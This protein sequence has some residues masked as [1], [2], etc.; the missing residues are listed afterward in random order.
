[1][2][3]DAQLYIRRNKAKFAAAAE[4]LLAPPS[5]TQILHRKFQNFLYRSGYFTQFV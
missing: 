3:R 4:I 2:C 5:T 1:M